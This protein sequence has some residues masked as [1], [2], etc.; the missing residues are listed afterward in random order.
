[1]SERFVG[2]ALGDRFLYIASFV[3]VHRAPLFNIVGAHVSVCR[4]KKGFNDVVGFDVLELG[5]ISL[6]T[7]HWGK[8][9]PDC[10]PRSGNNTRTV[11]PG[12]P[13][14]FEGR[15]TT[16]IVREVNGSWLGLVREILKGEGK[17][18]KI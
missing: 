5:A 8:E 10:K 18:K 9:D 1:V 15:A 13:D 2:D 4:K 17:K 11:P 3:S 12:G 14:S 7:S 16:T 6:L